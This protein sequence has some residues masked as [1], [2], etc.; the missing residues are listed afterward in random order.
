MDKQT[1]FFTGAGGF[2]GRY[3]LSHYLEQ[4]N[5]DLYLLEHGA[6]CERLR[7]FVESRVKDPDKRSRIHVLEGDITAPDLGLE[8]AMAAKLRTEMT[9]AIHLAAVYD[10]TVPKDIAARVNVDGTRRVLDFLGKAERLERFGYMSTTAISGTRPGPFNEDHFDE[11]QSFKNPYEETK[12]EAEKLVRERRD[13]IPTVIF[14]PT[15]VACDSKTGVFEKIDGPYYVLMAIARNMHLV[16]PDSGACKCHAEPVDFVADAFY[17]LLE[18]EQSTG[19]VF[20]LADPDPITYLEFMDLACERWGKIKPILKLPPAILKP[21]FR[22]PVSAFLTGVPYDAFKY[23]LNLVEYEATKT[24]PI[25]E[26]HG[27][28]CPPLTAYLDVMIQYFKEHHKDPGIRRGKL[29]KGLS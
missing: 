19:A 4:E 28:T 29:Y 18:D 17:C 5:T 24:T 14:R 16:V 20:H 7:A 12:F 22:L 26:K 10:V 11:G 25:L 15:V 8:A 27:I 23:S 9:R 1:V 3:I 13:T 6:F 21:I 2:I